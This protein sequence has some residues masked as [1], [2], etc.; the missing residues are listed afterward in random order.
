MFNPY[1][2]ALL[3]ALGL[4]GAVT[5]QAAT[6]TGDLLIGFTTQ[7][8]NDTVVDLGATSSLFDGETWDLSSLLGSYNLGTIN[9][10]VLG[11]KNSAGVR[12]AWSTDLNGPLANASAWGQLDTAT[13]SIYS[14][15]GT[16][17]AGQS[18]VIAA[19]DDN[20]WNQQTINGALP[21]QYHNVWGNPN[22]IGLGSETLYSMVA[23][24]SDPVALGSFA[25]GSNGSVLF[26]ATSVPEPGSY[27][28]LGGA[29]LLLVSLRN[30]LRR[31]VS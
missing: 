17:G 8:G 4:A 28:I 30:Q 6:Y 9:W 10:G 25:L 24:G 13:K 3:A 2:A 12:T 21:T 19:T 22:S 5:A 23:N 27:C 1:K 20:S 29:G 31:K 14:N 11:D 7:S 15:F 18:L 16:A 26:T